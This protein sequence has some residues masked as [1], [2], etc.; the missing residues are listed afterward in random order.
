VKF[1]IVGNKGGRY[2]LNK[3]TPGWQLFK[4]KDAQ[5]IQR[6]RGVGT[7][8][9]EGFRPMGLFP[10]TVQYAIQLVAED[11]MTE[12]NEKFEFKDG[13]RAMRAYLDGL[14]VNATRIVE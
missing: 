11:Y 9:K 13:M 2:L 4:W 8:G 14:S 3:E 7:M 6:G 1:E 5:I 12:S 10:S